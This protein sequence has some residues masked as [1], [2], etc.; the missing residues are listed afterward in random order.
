MG[1][2]NKIE[3]RIPALE[4]IRAIIADTKFLLN[5]IV[6][7][8]SLDK[9]FVY[10]YDD[11][12][13]LYIN[14]FNEYERKLLR[15]EYLQQ[16]AWLITNNNI[17]KMFNQVGKNLWLNDD[18]DFDFLFSKFY[19]RARVNFYDNLVRIFEII[20]IRNKVIN[21]R[22]VFYLSKYNKKLRRINK[23]KIRTYRGLRHNNDKL[24]DPKIDGAKNKESD[25]ISTFSTKHHYSRKVKIKKIY[26]GERLLRDQIDE[27]T[28]IYDIED[29]DLRTTADTGC[30][31]KAKG[32]EYN[33]LYDIEVKGELEEFVK[34]MRLF[35]NKPNIKDVRIIIDYLPE[36]KKG[37]KF[38]KL[39]DG[40]TKRRYV[41]GNIIMNDNKEYSL[42]EIEREERSLSRL[43][44]YSMQNVNWMRV[45][46]KILL[47]LV[48]KSGT[49]DSQG[50]KRLERNG[51]MIKRIR[52]KSG[53]NSMFDK[54]DYI[55]DKIIN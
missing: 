22:E 17:L 5:R 10:R 1:Y 54:C 40:E 21:A 14:F 9:Y 20:D 28:Q 34:I 35:K 53:K 44:L 4:I 13:N 26:D 24:L 45:Y 30:L 42:I 16:L 36:G 55:Y 52:H 7:L 49:W 25:F 46:L 39:S 47:G 3:Y 43:L 23:P 38:S 41:I 48:N 27:N 50:L 8:D 51:V 19:I 33:R 32:I 2:K 15:D 37:K 29:E 31:D 18:L 12:N 6:E 11:K